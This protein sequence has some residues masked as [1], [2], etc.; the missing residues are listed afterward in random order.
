M[1]GDKIYSFMSMLRLDIP[2]AIKV[3]ASNHDA[4]K[5]SAD[6]AFIA[7]MSSPTEAPATTFSIVAEDHRFYKLAFGLCTDDTV[8]AA[9]GV[10][11]PAVVAYH[12]FD[13]IEPL[14]AVFTGQQADFTTQALKA[15]VRNNSVPLVGDV[16]SVGYCSGASHYREACHGPSPVR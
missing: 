9:A 8:S 7:Y 5:A 13:P 11:P 12:T 15:F 6:V 4:V 1:T 10:L 14:R 16:A 2:M 3:T